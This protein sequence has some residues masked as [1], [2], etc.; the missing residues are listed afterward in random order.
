M[1]HI[2]ETRKW[3]LEERNTDFEILCVFDF[4]N[5]KKK[6]IGYRYIV[7]IWDKDNMSEKNLFTTDIFDTYEHAFDA[8]LK[9]A[10]E[11]FD[12]K[13][14]DV[15]YSSTTNMKYQYVD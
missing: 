10:D 7:S 9:N 15:F 11:Y 8:A 14:D 6:K 2:E 13:T 12:N 3:Y 5:S 4:V 1:N